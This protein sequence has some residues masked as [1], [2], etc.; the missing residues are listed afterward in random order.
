MVLL[1]IN[2]LHNQRSEGRRYAG[3]NLPQPLRRKIT[4]NIVFPY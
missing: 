3:C 4:E 2:Y 1:N